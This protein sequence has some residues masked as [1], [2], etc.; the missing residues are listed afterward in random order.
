M[1]TQHQNNPK[2]AAEQTSG[3]TQA[4]GHNPGSDYEETSGLDPARGTESAELSSLNSQLEQAQLELTEA[5]D[6]YLRLAA[7]LDNM[8][9][10]FERERS[11]L[12]KFGLEKVFMD[13]LPTLDS[14]DRALPGDTVATGGE[15]GSYLEGMLMVKKQLLDVLKRHGLEPVLS[16]NQAFDPN[17]HQAIQRVD[18]EEV[19]VETVKDEYA[20]G[21]LLHGRLL[22]P[23]MVSVLTPPLSN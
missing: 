22:R 4:S 8:R 12:V 2:T 14:L 1:D 17:L 7:E 3:A 9:R 23:A 16:A 5:K 21:Y 20:K 6:K 10:R 18:S 13:L 15:G 19:T 11:D